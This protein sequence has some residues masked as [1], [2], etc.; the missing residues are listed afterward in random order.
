[1]ANDNEDEGTAEFRAC[2]RVLADKVSFLSRH[3]A[4][5][6]ER[7]SRAE[8]AHGHLTKEL[9]EKKELVKSLYSKHQLEKQ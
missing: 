1:S 8:A 2:I 6:M 7:C 3:R 4:E 5:L 9:E